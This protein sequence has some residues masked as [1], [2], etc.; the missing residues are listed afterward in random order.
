MEHDQNLLSVLF[1]KNCFEEISNLIWKKKIYNWN[2]TKEHFKFIIEQE[3]ID[4]ILYFVKIRDCRV[5]LEDYGIQNRIVNKYMKYGSKIYYGAE[6]L[7]YV[8]KLNWN[9]DLTKD[10][11]KNI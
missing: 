9:N 6:M 4:L 2:F 10:L 11:C 3:Q 7:I 8:Y 5:I 1:Q